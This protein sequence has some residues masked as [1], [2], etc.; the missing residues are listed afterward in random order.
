MLKVLAHSQYN[1]P[2]PAKFSSLQ[3]LFCCLRD[4]GTGD[5]TYYPFSSVSNCIESY[6]FRI[7]SQIMQ[8]KAPNTFSEVFSEL[9][10]AIGS[11][12]DVNHQPS[13]E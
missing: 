12:S 6:Y 11:M 13:I 10:K 3:S 8:T 9:L 5:L 4:K 2:I 1:F 7:G